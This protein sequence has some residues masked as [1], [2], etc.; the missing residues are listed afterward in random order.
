MSNPILRASDIDVADDAEF[1]EDVVIE[2][3]TVRIG[4]GCRIGFSGDDD[5]RTPPGVRVSAESLVLDDGV[6]IGRGVAIRGGAIFIGRDVRVERMTTFAISERLVI[7]QGGV[8]GQANE[9]AGRDIE[10]GQ[11]LWT[12]PGARIGGGSAFEATSRLVAGH[13]LHLGLD[14]F[15]NTARPVSIGHEVG[16]GTRTTIYTHGAYASALRGFPVAFDGVSIGDFTWIPGGIVNP[17]VRIGRDCVIGVNSLVTSDIPD[18]A[19]AAGSPARVIR[20]AAYPRPLEDD[21]LLAFSESFLGDYAVLVGA[22]LATERVAGGVRLRS[23]DATYFLGPGDEPERV[24]DEQRRVLAVGADWAAEELPKGWTVFDTASRRITG[25]ADGAAARLANE[26]RRWGIRFYS[27]PE[28]E[29]YQAWDVPPAHQ[30][31]P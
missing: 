28:G 21:A 9:F 17:G 13:Y 6:C 31:H 18:G 24:A 27:R 1:G 22:K 11:E 23:A 30:D 25:S 10:I 8:V 12:G 5:F 20:E 7:G 16:L 3:D 14:T 2:A 26:L 15:V 4:A 19:L 29:S